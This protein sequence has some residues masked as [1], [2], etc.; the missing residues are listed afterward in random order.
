MRK[1]MEKANTNKQQQH[2]KLEYIRIL[3]SKWNASKNTEEKKKRKNKS[4]QQQTRHSHRHEN[5]GT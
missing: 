4:K 1:D 2:N 5:N 3:K